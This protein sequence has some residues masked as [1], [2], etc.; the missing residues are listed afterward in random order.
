V[1]SGLI[2]FNQMVTWEACIWES[3]DR[4]AGSHA[5]PMPCHDD[6]DK[7]DGDE[8]QSRGGDDHRVEPVDHPPPEGGEVGGLVVDPLLHLRVET[9]ESFKH[10][11]GFPFCLT[12]LSAGVGRLTTSIIQILQER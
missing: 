3:K 2:E 8:L 6:H 7:Q 1:T 4:R 10:L 12:C 5:C 11:A 9:P